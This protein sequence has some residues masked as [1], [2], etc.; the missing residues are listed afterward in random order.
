M[1]AF[2]PGHAAPNGEYLTASKIRFRF[3]CR[4][5]VLGFVSY[6]WFCVIVSAD[7][8][9]LLY[10]KLLVAY[11]IMD[12]FCL[13][14]DTVENLSQLRWYQQHGEGF[15]LKTELPF[16]SA[17]QM[18]MLPGCLAKL[19]KFVVACWVTNK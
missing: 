15:C 18:M 13:L 8:F 16:V 5:A 17:M 10:Y 19:C 7:Q 4:L 12:S 3:Y 14:Q 2:A 9:D 6:T 1:N 11:G